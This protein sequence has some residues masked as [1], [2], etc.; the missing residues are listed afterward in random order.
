MKTLKF[1]FNNMGGCCRLFAIP[2]TSFLRIREDYVNGLHYIECTNYDDII[3]IPVNADGTFYF[4]ENHSSEDAGDGYS[5]EIGGVIPKLMVENAEDMEILERGEWYVLFMDNNDDVKLAGD[6][7]VKLKFISQKTT[8]LLSAD[9]NQIAFTFSCL[10][11]N[12][13]ICIALTDMD[14]L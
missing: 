3:D 7:D 1:D 6:E 2:P 12:P 4:N 13:S 14:N 9:R 10:Q 11:T 5:V 8:G